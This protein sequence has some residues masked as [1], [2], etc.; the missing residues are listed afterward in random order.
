MHARLAKV[1]PLAAAR[2][3]VND[4]QRVQR[5]LEVYAISGRPL[6]SFFAQQQLD[7]DYDYVKLI[8]APEQRKTLHDKIALRFDAML[9]QGLLGEVQR[10]Y[11]RSDLHPGL[12]SIRC[13]G[14]R[15]AWSYLDGEFDLSTM[16]EKAI[17]ATRQ[18]A[19]RQFTWLR[20]EQDANWLVSDAPDLLERALVIC[21]NHG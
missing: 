17:I 16:R 19:K 15:Q 7:P 14:Y 4:P 1:D 21:R 2:I 5:A 13:V 3:H 12:P 11:Q 20:K 10:L 6:S 8:V 9:K 18:L